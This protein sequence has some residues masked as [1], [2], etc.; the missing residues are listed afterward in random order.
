MFYAAYN[1]DVARSVLGDSIY[2][3]IYTNTG[4]E[5]GLSHYYYEI[6]RADTSSTATIEHYK[7]LSIKYH[8]LFEHIKD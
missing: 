6:I 1:E 5:P 8:A 2:M 4:A 3:V 7:Q